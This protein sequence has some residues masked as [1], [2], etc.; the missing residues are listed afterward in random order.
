MQLTFGLTKPIVGF[1]VTKP[2]LL[3]F[4]SYSSQAP[5]LVK[6]KSDINAVL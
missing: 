4:L 2:P 6:K 5:L 3:L 1:F